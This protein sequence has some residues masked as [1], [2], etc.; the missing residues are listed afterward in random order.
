MKLIEATMNPQSKVPFFTKDLAN[1]NNENALYDRAALRLVK[2]WVI[3]DT[4]NATT[5]S[6]VR[7]LEITTTRSCG[8]TSWRWTSLK[9]I[10]GYRGFTFCYVEFLDSHLNDLIW[11]MNCWWSY[12]HRSVNVS[13]MIW[14]GPEN[15]KVRYDIQMIFL[16][17]SKRF[18]P[19]LKSD[20]LRRQATFFQVFFQLFLWMTFCFNFEPPTFMHWLMSTLIF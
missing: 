19:L 2:K 20:H 16:R 6:A 12:G 11:M 14:V 8:G 3:D 15:K 13:W 9:K 1:E 4:W 5:P 17:K 10:R 7:W 18:L